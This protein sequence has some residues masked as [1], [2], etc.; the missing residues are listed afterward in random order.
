MSKS[1][2]P[3][4]SILLFFAL[5]FLF[6]SCS[7]DETVNPDYVGTWSVAITKGGDEIKDNI[8][9]TKEGF[10]ETLQIYDATTT[11]WT[12]YKTSAGIISIKGTTLTSTYKSIGLAVPD[13]TT[14]ELTGTILT[15]SEG[16]DTFN[17]FFS[18]SGVPQTFNSQFSVSGNKLTLMTDQ[19]GDGV[20]TDL[21]ETLVFTKQ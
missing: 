17:M 7:K 8:T 20:Y 4:K 12:T 13:L 14:G 1:I 19:N 16:S 6:T 18:E 10:T 2:F 9:Y 11:K 15:Y 21:G 3:N 5:V